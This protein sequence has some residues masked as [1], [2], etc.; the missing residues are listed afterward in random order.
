MQRHL[1]S[2]IGVQR[3]VLMERGHDSSEFLALAYVKLFE[4]KHKISLRQAV[5]LLHKN[6]LNSSWN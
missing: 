2:F 6:L 5:V 3:A 4:P 1:N